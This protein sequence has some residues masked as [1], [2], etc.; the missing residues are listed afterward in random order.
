MAAPID[1]TDGISNIYMSTYLNSF[2]GKILIE[3]IWEYNRPTNAMYKFDCG[4]SSEVNM[5]ST[6][7]I[8]RIYD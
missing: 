1:N 6:R 7:N 8:N 4:S 5:S 2:I 3:T